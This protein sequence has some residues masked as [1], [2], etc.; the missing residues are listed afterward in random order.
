MKYV[1]TWPNQAIICTYTTI[2][3]D[4]TSQ[5]C[6]VIHINLQP[7]GNKLVFLQSLGIVFQVH[8][9]YALRIHS[10]AMAVLFID[11]LLMTHFSFG[12]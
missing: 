8:R 9:S 6:Q 10:L 2:L 3:D 12:Y 11:Q 1:G 5:Y 7:V 4:Y